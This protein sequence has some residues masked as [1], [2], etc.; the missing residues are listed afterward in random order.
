MDVSLCF[1]LKIFR[2]MRAKIYTTLWMLFAFIAVNSAQLKITEI[3]YNPPESGT[4]SLEYIELYNAG[5]AVL[6]LK[7]FK[8]TKGVE[9]TFE[10]YLM[11]PGTYL[12]VAVNRA[13]FERNYKKSAIQWTTGALNNNGEI[14]AIAD[15]AGVEV[16]SVD[17]KDVSPWPGLAE[18]TDGNGRSIELC[19]PEADPN[20]GHNWKVSEHDLGFQINGKQMYGTPGEAN[21][22]TCGITPDYTIEVALGG[23]TPKDLTIEVG[24]IV[25][26]SNTNGNNNIN[27]DKKT[28]GA[29]PVSFGNGNPSSDKWTYDFKFDV[30]GF[31]EYQSDPSGIKGSVTVKPKAVI[32]AYPF[33]TI[34][35]VKGVNASGVADSLGIKCTLEG[36]VHSIN[37]RPT[38]L[39]FAI[40]DENNKGFGVFSSSN[41]F[42]YTVTPG[43]KIRV[44]GKIG[45]FRGLSQIEADS[46]RL[47]STNNTLVKP[48]TVSEFSEDLE[49]SY[50]TLSNVTFQDPT[51]WNNS[52]TGFNVTMTDGVNDFTVRIVNTSNAFSAPIPS[53]TKFN[54]TGI[55]IQF[56]QSNAPFSGGYQLQPSYITDFQALSNTQDAGNTNV[57]VSPNPVTHQI[58]IHA[59][60]TPERIDII[61]V[62]GQVVKAV[63]GTNTIDFSNMEAS[64]YLLRIKLANQEVVKRIIKL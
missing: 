30:P 64:I 55:V 22:V 63:L 33:R 53:G 32:D 1:T 50:V 31:Y 6:D 14:I 56:A 52:G 48:K 59:D 61:D 41:D 43:D 4:D 17:F 60:Q 62:K 34:A 13:A 9:H 36:V 5:S 29:N 7:D 21:S 37:Y 47:V 23:F 39:Q 26:W 42:G 12:V 8:F 3:S 10:A 51:Q 54:V 19:N 27:G 44:K 35:E 38:G 40:L 49:S 15:A 28:F 2:H 58:Y 11:Q 16:I 25:R 57:V 18:G 45:Q 20:D 46:F 24:E